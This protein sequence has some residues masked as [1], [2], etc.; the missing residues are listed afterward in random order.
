MKKKSLFRGEP[1]RKL[2]DEKEVQLLV[3]SDDVENYRLI[4]RDLFIL[5]NLTEKS[6]LWVH[7]ERHHS[8]DSK[9][10]E[11]EDK[12]TKMDFEEHL[13]FTSK[14]FTSEDILRSIIDIIDEHYSNSRK[15]CLRLLNQVSILAR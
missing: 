10:H 12:I 1:Q 7:G 11:K 14:G 6:E 3:S 13:L 8:I 5:K 2:V 15:D 4:D 9:D